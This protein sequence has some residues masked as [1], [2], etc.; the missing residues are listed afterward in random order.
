ME[1]DKLPVRVIHMAPLSTGG[2]SKLTVTIHKFLDKDKVQFDYLVFRNNKEFLEDEIIKLGGKKK[3]VDVGDVKNPLLKCIKKI[4]L[5]RNLFKNEKY[6]VV[7]VDASTPYDVIVAIA[8][9]LA[10]IKTIIMHSHNNSFHKNIPLRDIFMGWYK[11]IMLFTVTDYFAISESSAHF[12][13]PKSVLKKRNYYIVRNAID[14]SDYIFSSSDRKKYRVESGLTDK[15]VIGHI[16]RFVYQKNHDFIIDVF[17]QIH[18]QN[19]ESVLLLIGEGPLQSEIKTKVEKLGLSENV[20]FYG[21]THNIRKPLLM[22]DVFIFP[23]RFEG[24]GIVA[25]EAQATGLLVAAADTIVDEVNITDCFQRIH[26]W[27]VNEW[28]ES[29]CSFDYSKRKNCT[30]QVINAGYDIKQVA[31]FMQ[32]FYIMNKRGLT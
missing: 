22:M 1:R 7:H 16:G 12:M 28:A 26:G 17:K 21:T 13:F 30:D 19:S 8:A 10:G 11:K 15:F 4:V 27:N 24:L 23:S 20:I 14:T 2:I 9:K 6:D 3:L 18:Q 31:K 25:I 5:M 32:E 29:I